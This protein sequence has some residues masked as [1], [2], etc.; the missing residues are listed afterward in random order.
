MSNKKLLGLGI[1]GGSV[2]IGLFYLKSQADKLQIGSVKMKGKKVALTHLSIFIDFP[3]INPTN[4]SLPFTSFKGVWSYNDHNIANINI[5]PA[6]TMIKANSTVVLP[7]EVKIS[8]FKA[9]AEIE[10]MINSKSFLGASLIKGTVLSGGLSF[11]TQSK[12]F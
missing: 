7:V 5:Q 2:G 8:Y 4:T 3:I 12:V 9:A 6:T 1:I 11:D 10:D